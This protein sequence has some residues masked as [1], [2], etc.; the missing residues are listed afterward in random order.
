MATKFLIALSG[1]FSPNLIDQSSCMSL[2]PHAKT[3]PILYDDW[4]I[5][6]GENRLYRCSQ[7]FG[8]YADCKLFY[9]AFAHCSFKIN[10]A[11][12]VQQTLLVGNFM[13]FLNFHK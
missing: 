9:C 7:T 11:D 3:R 13:I 10:K 4:S 2:T 5:R 6:L 1:L 8:G 12:G